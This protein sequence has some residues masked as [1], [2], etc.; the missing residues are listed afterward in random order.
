MS[1]FSK[2]LRTEVI[3]GR[4]Y[5]DLEQ[6]TQM[7]FDVTNETTKEAT[8]V[9]DP[10]LGIMALGLSHFGKALD[11]TL[12]LQEEAHGLRDQPQRC[13]VSKPHP[14]HLIMRN[15]KTVRCPGVDETG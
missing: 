2:A 15:R 4:V 9:R 7:L 12:T 8:K 14:T 5:V 13:G 11:G 1:M 10:A 3:N 6:L